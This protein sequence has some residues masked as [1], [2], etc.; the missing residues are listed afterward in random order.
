MEKTIGPNKWKWY[1]FDKN[2]SERIEPIIENVNCGSTGWLEQLQEHKTNFLRIKTLDN[3]KKVVTGSLIYQQNFE[4]ELDYKIFHFYVSTDQ[5]ITVDL[6]LSSFKHIHTEDL[7]RLID[8]TENPVD[9]FLIF[10]GELMN[11][12]LYEIDQFEDALKTLIWSVRKRNETSILEKI[13]TQRHELL[14]W[15]NLLI[16][17]KELKMGIEEINLNEVSTG[18]IFKTTCKRIER[19][20][21]LLNEYE[22]ELDSIINLEEVISSHRGNEIM[23]TLTV[24]TTIF[25]PVMAF[26]SLWGMNFKHMPE[27][28]WKF[29]YIM[30]VILIIASTI[31]LYGFLKFNGWTG[32]LLRGKKKG[33]FFK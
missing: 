6:M 12:M 15:K 14:V 18:D 2:D 5:L 17:I 26:G 25:T 1:Q 28:E 3:G 33:S 4:E 8:R 10:L 13:Y 27:L 20:V 19:A 21:E 29:G 31:L 7:L 24:I 30:S 32:D 11:E 23:K 9:G 22:H 16:P